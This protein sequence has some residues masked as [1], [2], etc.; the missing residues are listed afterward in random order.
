MQSMDNALR[1]L[2]DAQIITGEEAYDKAF[3][4]ADFER[5]RKGAATTTL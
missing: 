5:Y 4:K 2:I 3:R 1:R